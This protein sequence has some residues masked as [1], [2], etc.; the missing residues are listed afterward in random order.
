MS[1]SGADTGY[2]Y[3][4]DATAY[5]AAHGLAGQPLAW[6]EEGHD[7][8]ARWLAE[9]GDAGDDIRIIT[10][11]NR[12]IEV[13]AKHAAT[14]GADFD[15]AFH[16]LVAGLKKSPELRVVFLVDRHAS[17]VIRNDL[18]HDIVRLGQGRTDALKTATTELLNTL[19]ETQKPLPTYFLGCA[20]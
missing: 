17:G 13:Q 14:R 1:G 3:Q 20:L 19:G 15:A 5:V 8:P 4:A 7:V 9:T 10:V 18:K 16:R 2:D 6:F 12:H 11:E